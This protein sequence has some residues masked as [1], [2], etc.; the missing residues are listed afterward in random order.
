MKRSVAAQCMH[1]SDDR[2][3]L[4]RCN[5]SKAAIRALMTTVLS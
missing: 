1:I 4:A 2:R 5:H 3:V